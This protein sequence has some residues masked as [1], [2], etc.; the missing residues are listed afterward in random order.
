MT[1]AGGLAA[2]YRADGRSDRCPIIDVHGHM[3]TFAGIYMPRGSAEAMIG[4][5]DRCGVRMLVFCHFDA[6]FCPDVG[7]AANV[8]AVRRYPDRLRAYLGVNPNHPESL[9]RDLASFDGLRD[10]YAGLK[11]LASYHRTPWDSP[12]YDRAWRFADE[13]R[14]PVLA[15]TWGHDIFNGQQ[16]VRKA[17]AKY[18]NVRLIIGHSLWGA[19]DEAVSIGREFSNVYLDLTAV[20]SVRGPLE[21]F[22]AAGLTK[23]VLFGTDLPWFD[24]QHGVGSLLSSSITEDDIHNICHRNAEKLLGL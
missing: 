16:Q 3:G 23:K 4:T 5:M 14:L 8:E 24:E 21:R 11:I 1:R 6:L 10:V 2:D 17:A 15:H 7:N 18:P 9:E 13:R 22:V 20:L 19:W 12:A